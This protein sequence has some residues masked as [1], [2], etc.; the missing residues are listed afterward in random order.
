MDMVSVS[1]ILPRSLF[2]SLS[3]FHTHTSF[4]EAQMFFAFQPTATQ[5][6]PIPDYPI[7]NEPDQSIKLSPT[8]SHRASNGHANFTDRVQTS[9][10][11]LNRYG[12][13]MFPLYHNLNNTVETKGFAGMFPI[14]PLKT[15]HSKAVVYNA[16]KG[17]TSGYRERRK[18]NAKCK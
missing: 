14:N 2:S 17:C 15:E 5:S 13:V 9:Q 3:L 6:T 10:L 7:L 1:L 8:K 11:T 18:N 4:P 12:T 16:E